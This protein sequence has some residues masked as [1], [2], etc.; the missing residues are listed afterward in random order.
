MDDLIEMH[1]CDLQLALEIGYVASTTCP[2]VM[3]FHH[4]GQL[5]TKMNDTTSTDGTRQKKRRDGT[6]V[7]ADLLKKAYLCSSH[8]ADVQ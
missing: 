7:T 3:S 8:C 5:R 4:A 2:C 6:K 1:V